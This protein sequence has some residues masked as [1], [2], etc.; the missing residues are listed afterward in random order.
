MITFSL[1][2]LLLSSNIQTVLYICSTTPHQPITNEQ[3]KEAFGLLKALH[4][5]DHP[6]HCPISNTAACIHIGKVKAYS[7]AQEYQTPNHLLDYRAMTKKVEMYPVVYSVY[8]A[9][10]KIDKMMFV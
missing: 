7:Q 10:D 1:L 8:T 5:T 3:S 9:L 4:I 6:L 2:T